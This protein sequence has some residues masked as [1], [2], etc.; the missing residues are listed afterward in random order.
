[1][2]SQ[3]RPISE[4][5]DGTGHSCEFEQVTHKGKWVALYVVF[6][7]KRIAQRGEPGGPHAR[8][9]VSLVPGYDVV[10][11]DSDEIEVRFEGRVLQ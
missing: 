7:G 8:T 1:M 3:F 10:D 11:L 6:D 9:W 2:K 5:L 4:G